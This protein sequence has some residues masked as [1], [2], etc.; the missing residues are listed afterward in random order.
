LNTRTPSTA[1]MIEQGLPAAEAITSAFLLKLTTSLDDLLWLSPFL[2][3]SP[4]V[5]NKF[6]HSIVYFIVCIFVTIVAF[7]FGTTLLTLMS[8]G[9]EVIPGYWNPERF[10]SILSSSVLLYIARNEYLEWLED[11]G[12]SQEGTEREVLLPTTIETGGLCIDDTSSSPKRRHSDPDADNSIST[13]PESQSLTEPGM[14]NDD[15]VDSE[16]EQIRAKIEEAS[17]SLKR[18]IAVCVMG[19]LDDMIVFSAFVAGGGIYSIQ[20]IGQ[21]YTALFVGTTCAALLIVTI[22]WFFSEIECFKRAVRSIPVWGLLTGVGVY[23]LVM[24]LLG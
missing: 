17:K 23:I 12:D 16:D 15:S 1:T 10:L 20:G 3:L 14:N 18:F 21:C 8:H 19:T 24:G 7:I 5:K 11:N 13:M 9:D 4:S 2:S 22:S 6:T